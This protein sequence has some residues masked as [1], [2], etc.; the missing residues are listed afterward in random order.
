MQRSLT[1]ALLLIGPTGRLLESEALHALLQRGAS[2]ASV[3]AR[4]VQRSASA[5]KERATR[6]CKRNA[7]CASGKEREVQ[8]SASAVKERATRFCKGNAPCASGKEREVQRSASA[9][10]ERSTRIFSKGA[11]GAKE[12]AARTGKA[13]PARP[14][15]APAGARACSAPLQR[16]SSSSD[17][18]GGFWKA[19]RSTRFCKG[20]PH[21][22]L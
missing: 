14:A 11:Q 19:K 9:V 18:R 7:P 13:G 22:L 20:A 1:E 10:K 16:R 17:R 2:R 5:V 4:E 3:N 15:Y 12:R 6:F 8:R 21:A